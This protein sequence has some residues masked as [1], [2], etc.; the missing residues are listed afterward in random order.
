MASAELKLELPGGPASVALDAGVFQQ[1]TAEV[2]FPLPHVGVVA[3]RVTKVCV[4]DLFHLLRLCRRQREAPPRIV[5]LPRDFDVPSLRFLS[6]DD[7]R[8]LPN[9]S[10]EDVTSPEDTRA[11]RPG[12][13]LKR[14]HWKLS[15]RNREMIV[16]RFEIPAPPDTLILMDCCDPVCEGGEPDGLARLRD[17]L[18]ETALSVAKAQMERE[19]PVRMPL[20]G[21]RTGEFRADRT[22]SLALLRE[23]LAYQI[24]R[25]GEPFDQVLN[26]ELRRM[27]RT[28]ATVVITTRLDA[29]I[30][31]GVKHIRRMGSSVR[32]CLV[33]FKADDEAYAPY[34]TQLQ[35]DLVEVC[36]VT[37]A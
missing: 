28:G 20:Y 27:R 4:S 26:L 31:E 11:Y 24:F 8:A 14:V 23:E 13:P 3:A 10:S 25:G 21:A 22:G 34:I 35:H 17:T 5:V 6:R 32:F 19:R 36:H 29:R 12:D 15:A 7:G 33:T 18:C 16:R 2:S 9:R 1:E 30:V 37:P